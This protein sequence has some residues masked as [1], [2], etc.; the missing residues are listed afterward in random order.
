MTVMLQQYYGGNFFRVSHQRVK[1]LELP[2]ARRPLQQK[3]GEQ[4]QQEKQP[5]ARV[6][7]DTWVSPS[8]TVERYIEHTKVAM[9]GPGTGRLSHCLEFWQT[10]TSD[11]SILGM[12]SGLHL[13]FIEG[14]V[15]VQYNPVPPGHFPSMRRS[16]QLLIL[17]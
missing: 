13:D 3:Q 2:Q 11:R 4:Q 1:P 7:Q 10:I 12:V 14:Q 5:E 15:P 16:K 17:R 6:T 8:P 9:E